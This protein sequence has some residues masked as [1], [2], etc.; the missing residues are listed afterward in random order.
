MDNIN[1]NSELIVKTID[2]IGIN[3]LGIKFE[4]LETEKINSTN[5]IIKKIIEL[6]KKSNNIG[7]FDILINILPYP[8]WIEWF[9]SCFIL[10]YYWDDELIRKIQ[11]SNKMKINSFLLDLSESNKEILSNT[12]S[13]THLTLPTNRE[14]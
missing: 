10:K 1:I 5:N 12:V 13:Y 11:D 3:N 4:Q 14:V 8:I 7:V 9:K 6:I 2:I